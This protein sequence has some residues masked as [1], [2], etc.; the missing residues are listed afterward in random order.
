M[1]E[2]PVAEQREA[3]LTLSGAA[4]ASGLTR[5]VIRRLKDAGLFPHAFKDDEGVWRIPLDDLEILNLHPKRALGE[6]TRE[7]PSAAHRLETLKSEVAILQERLSSAEAIARERAERIEDL[8]LVLRVLSGQG[9]RGRLAHAEEGLALPEA[10]AGGTDPSLPLVSLPETEVSSARPAFAPS[11]NLAREND[12][13]LI[14]GTA[15]PENEERDVVAAGLEMPP[16]DPGV[17][18]GGD[19]WDRPRRRFRWLRRRSKQGP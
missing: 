3:A 10:G 9:D 12:S 15:P 11:S 18:T 14:W 6:E 5:E 13:A 1:E 16:H 17:V 8:R 7:E 2:A 4:Q 19:E